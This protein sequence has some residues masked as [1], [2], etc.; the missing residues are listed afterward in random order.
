MKI[1]T[2]ELSLRF[3]RN[4]GDAMEF[5]SLWIT[6]KIT[7]EK[8]ERHGVLMTSPQRILDR[9]TKIVRGSRP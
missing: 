4:S 9:A 5:G 3:D 1:E 6:N 2:P 7:G 8:Y